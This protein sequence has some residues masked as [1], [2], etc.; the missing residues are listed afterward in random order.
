MYGALCEEKVNGNNEFFTCSD[1]ERSVV[2]LSLI[3]K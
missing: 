3:E 1:S 2:Y